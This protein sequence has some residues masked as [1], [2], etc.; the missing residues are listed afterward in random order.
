MCPANERQ[1]YN[2]TSSLIGWVHAP[3]DLCN[4]TDWFLRIN[5]PALQFNIR[6]LFHLFFN[7]FV[8]ITTVALIWD[9]A[10]NSA[11]AWTEHVTLVAITGTTILVPY[12][13]FQATATHLEIG[14][15]Q[16]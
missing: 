11:S 1:R 16:I 8:I 7:V 4:N 10:Q 2:V 9:P 15:L 12:F 5:M 14:N 6:K 13:V 3:N